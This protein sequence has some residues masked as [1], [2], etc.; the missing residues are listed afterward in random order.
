MWWL[1]NMA[2]TLKEKLPGLPNDDLQ[3]VYIQVLDKVGH[4]L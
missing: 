4:S 2:M 1:E 3:Q